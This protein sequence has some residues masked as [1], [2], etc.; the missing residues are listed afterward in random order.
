MRYMYN[1][2]IHKMCG[3]S[4]VYEKYVVLDVYTKNVRI[5]YNLISIC[6]YKKCAVFV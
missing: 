2:N 3:F 6:I 1:F 5:L 4:L